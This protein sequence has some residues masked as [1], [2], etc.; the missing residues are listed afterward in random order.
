LAFAVTGCGKKEEK[1]AEK[2]KPAPVEKKAEPAP[3]EEKAAEPAPV[4]E[5]AA[6]PAPVEEKAA[7]PAPVEEKK[8]ETAPVEE[9]KVEPAAE[10]PVEDKEAKARQELEERRQKIQEI[11]R[12]GRSGNPEDVKKLEEIIAGEATQPFEKATAIRALG[13]NK[14]EAL[15]PA[16]KTLAESQDLAVKS[17]AVI[18][19]YQWGDKEFAKPQMEKLLD[20]GVALRRAFFKGIQDGKY[21][22]EPEAEEFFTK[23]LEAKQVHVKLDAALGLLHLEKKDTAIKAFSDAL[24]DQDKEYV[25]LTAVSY[26]ASARDIAEAKALLEKAANDSSPKVSNRAKQILGIAA[27]TPAPAPA[28][29]E[30]APAAAP[31]PAPAE[32]TPAAA[33][34][35]TAGGPAGQ[36]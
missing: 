12:L 16:L 6:E 26:L 34:A 23:A 10:R 2:A 22:Y 4:E 31:A 36:P 35:P 3:A 33:P 29:A 15:M 13:S 32:G 30:G 1:A 17:E 11:Y 24:A 21:L 27:P 14:N 28:P 5:K 20:Q 9:K 25:R 19:L 8:V 7:E 18:V